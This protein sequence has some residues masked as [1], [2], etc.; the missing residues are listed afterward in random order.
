MRILHVNI[1]YPPF[2]G[3]AQVFLQQVA[4]RSCRRGHQV[5]VY[6]SDAGEIEHLWTR[7]KARLES[8]AFMDEDVQVHRFPV[9]HLPLLPY[10]YHALRRLVVELNRLPCVPDAFLWRYAR[11][12][13]WLPDL[14]RALEG[15]G[16]EYDVVHGWNIPFESLLGPAWRYARRR[17]IPFVLTP[18]L[19]LGEADGSGVR[20]FYTARH[21][22]ALL[23]ES[24]A[25][26]ALTPLEAAYIV[27]QG[28]PESRVHVVAGG[29]DEA[30]LRR[31]DP[32]RFRAR[33]GI[34]RP[35]V[36]YLGAVHYHKGAHHLVQAMA[37]LWARGQ[38]ADLVMAGPPLAQFL[39]FFQHLPPEQRA[40]CHLLGVLS[41]EEKADAL[42]ACRLLALPSRTESFGLV[43]LEAWAL[44]KPVVGARAGAVP[45]VIEDGV[46]GLLVPFGD[47]QALASAL[48][49]LLG[50]PERAEALGRAGQRKVRDR[51]TWEAAEDKINRIYRQVLDRKARA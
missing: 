17:G 4:R 3:G 25:V 24:D 22:L 27:E 21:Q 20:R 30:Q 23:R 26:I 45:A 19:H 48:A 29:V 28:V 32:A 39:A 33:W 5:T 12:I 13:P 18:L 9:R 8:G 43:Y 1:G 40:R 38:E 51:F 2:I 31:G 46:D 16:D 37:E 10:S 47:V 35:F 41:E 34:T 44:G 15:N 50:D 42:A 6:T 11:F 49:A 36:L 14:D 7:G